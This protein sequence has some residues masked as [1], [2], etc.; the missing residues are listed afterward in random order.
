MSK[1]SSSSKNNFLNELIHKEKK[2]RKQGLSNDNG[3]QPY[4]A[5]KELFDN[6]SDD[7]ILLA[8][9]AGTGKS[10]GV[11]EYIVH[12]IKKYPNSRALVSRRF[13]KSM[14]TTTLV[15][16]EN[17]VLGK[18]HP[19]VTKGGKR[20][21]RQQYDFPNGS[22]IVIGGLD[23]PETIMGAEYDLIFVSEAIQVEEDAW[24]DLI[25][26]LRN[27]MVPVM[28][29]IGDTNP[30]HPRH[31]LKRRC[32]DG[33]CLMIDTKHTDNPLLYNQDTGEITARGIDYMSKLDK[34]SGIKKKRNKYGLWVS[35]EGIVYEDFTDEHHVISLLEIPKSFI[36]KY[37]VIDFGFKNPF[38]CQWW[39][40]DYDG[41]LYMYREIYY[42]GLLVE[43]AAKLINSN[44]FDENGNPERYNM[45]IHDHDAEG[46]ATLRKHISVDVGIFKNAKKKPVT[47]GIEAVKKRIELDIRMRPSIYFCDDALVHEP[48][49]N[50]VNS[51]KPTCSREEI[52]VYV[53]DKRSKITKEV[54]VKE[55]DHGLDCTRYMV[56]ELDGVTSEIEDKIFRSAYI[57]DISGSGIHSKRNPFN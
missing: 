4:G 40:L 21:Y 6:E 12:Y 54:P 30:S 25:S 10:R 57:P 46:A 37:L 29:I 50:L 8:G 19:S 43:D 28:R 3:Y 11:L 32:D 23:N 35:Q 51:G 45:V 33:R 39:G 27:G 2:R 14:N 47:G 5:A 41:S 31:W 15:T 18:D 16:L 52:D 36:A 56:A 34:L 49:E 9:P 1:L 44:S 24:E 55:N 22:E 17:F 38:V 53:W 42:T 13:R 48:D 7:E 20:N 26:R